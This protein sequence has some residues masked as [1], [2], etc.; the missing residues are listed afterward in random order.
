MTPDAWQAHVT[1]EAAR[2][3]GRWLEGRGRLGMPVSSLTL[4]DLEAMASAAICRFVL[5][6]SER[7]RDQPAES[8][9]LTR[10]LLG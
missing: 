2:E 3:I 8:A 4:A 1:R 10:L 6:G 9:D 5:L 7:I